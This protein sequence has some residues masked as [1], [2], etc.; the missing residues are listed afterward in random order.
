MGRGCIESRI[1]FWGFPGFLILHIFKRPLNFESTEFSTLTTSNAQNSRSLPLRKHKTPDHSRSTLTTLGLCEVEEN[2]FC[3]GQVFF[4]TI[5]SWTIVN[6]L[7]LCEVEEHCICSGHFFLNTIRS[8]KFVNS[9]GLCEV[10]E[11]C[12]CSGQVLFNTI[13]SWTI[14]NSLRLCEVNDNCCCSRQVCL[15]PFAL[16]QL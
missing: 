9:L 1:C 15:I 16:G 6:S 11:K 10:E 2:C 14:V 7:G 8:W 13:R 4:N 12:F 5:R 3:S